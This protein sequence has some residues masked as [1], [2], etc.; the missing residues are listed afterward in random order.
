MPLVLGKTGGA[1]HHKPVLRDAQLLPQGGLRPVPGPCRR[2]H[3]VEDHLD[4]I[5]G[6]AVGDELF[7]SLV[8]HGD[9]LILPLVHPAVGQAGQGIVGQHEVV[10]VYHPDV[11][12]VLLGQQ[13]GVVLPQVVA[14]DQVDLP[15]PAQLGQ[16]FGRLEVKAAAHLHPA[17]GHAHLL[18]TLHQEPALVV[19][20][21]GLHPGVV[22]IA[23][24][25]LYIPLGAGLPGKVEQIEDLHHKK[26][27]P[28]LS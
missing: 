26:D 20:E 5:P 22:Q 18:Q 13:G 9:H 23:D 6:P 24:Q 14:V 3:R 25:R 1:E 4:P 12:V 2:V 16:L 19:G 11:G 17:T 8:T 27:P 7:L 10:G 15:L 28:F 21:I